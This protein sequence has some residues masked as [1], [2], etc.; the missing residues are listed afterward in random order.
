MKILKDFGAT[1]V[2]ADIREAEDRWAKAEKAAGDMFIAC[3]VSSSES[4]KACFQKVFDTYGRLFKTLSP[5]TKP[6]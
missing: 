6:A 2:V 4:I 1:V 5:T 3:D